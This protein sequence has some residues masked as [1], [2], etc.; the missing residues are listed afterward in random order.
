MLRSL[1]PFFGLKL[2]ADSVAVADQLDD[3]GIYCISAHIKYKFRILQGVRKIINL[4][5]QKKYELLEKSIVMD[6]DKT[7][8][9]TV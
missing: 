3:K 8:D 7:D 6:Q 5:P 2:P 1:G 9:R 4:K